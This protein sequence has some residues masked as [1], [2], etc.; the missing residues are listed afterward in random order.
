MDRVDCVNFEGLQAVNFMMD[1]SVRGT[2]MLSR[3]GVFLTLALGVSSVSGPV[4]AHHGNAAYDETTP[5]RIK[6]SLTKF[7]WA[8]P[9]V[10]I[11]LDVK[12]I[13]G[14]VMHWSVESLSPER[15]ARMGW[16]KDSVKPGDEVTIDLSAAKNG[17][18]VGY[19]TKLVFADGTELR[20]KEGK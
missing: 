3:L 1:V 8:N 2:W 12:D 19:L 10:Y 20:T 6:G 9:H 17:T 11:Y 7:D 4:L 13:D 16:T 18:P 15:M 5:V 14:L